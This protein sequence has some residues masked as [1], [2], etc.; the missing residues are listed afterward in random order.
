VARRQA[1]ALGLG[2]DDLIVSRAAVEELQGALYCL[3]AALDDVDRDLAAGSD[4]AEVK[5]AL[6]WL[7]DNARPLAALW[8]E[9]RVADL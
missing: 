3:A 4:P 9:P 1:Q 2:D 6:D 7:R 5:A 8:I